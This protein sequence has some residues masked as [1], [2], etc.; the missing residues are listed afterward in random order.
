[1]VLVIKSITIST[2]RSLNI[3]K[4]KILFVT[5]IKN[6]KNGASINLI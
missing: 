4:T 6:S 3:F 2:N 1:M 5:E